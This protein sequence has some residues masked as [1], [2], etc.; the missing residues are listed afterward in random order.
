M[1]NK[2]HFTHSSFSKIVTTDTACGEEGVALSAPTPTITCD[3]CIK[4]LKTGEKK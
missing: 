4:F 2:I 3:K 1:S